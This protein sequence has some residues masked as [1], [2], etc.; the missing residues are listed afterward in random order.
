MF[1]FVETDQFSKLVDG[2]LTDEEYRQV[3]LELI[4][5]PE[6]GV[7]IRGSG[8]VRKLRWQAHHLFRPTLRENVLDA[9]D[10]SQKC[11]RYDSRSSA[12]EDSTGN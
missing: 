10:L 4:R 3:Q 6:A 9:H 7:V 2:Y 8:G 1:S 12:E 5:N 11:S